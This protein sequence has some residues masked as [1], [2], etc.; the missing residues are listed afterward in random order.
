M[1]DA[2]RLD[3][4]MICERSLADN[5]RDKLKIRRNSAHWGRSDID[6]DDDSDYDHRIVLQKFA[7]TGTTLSYLVGRHEAVL[8]MHVSKHLHTGRS[9]R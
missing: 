3:D 6:D 8:F 2:L 7:S 4:V 1:L 5:G 9:L